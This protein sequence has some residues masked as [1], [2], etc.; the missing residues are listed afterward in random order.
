VRILEDKKVNVRLQIEGKHDRKK[1]LHLNFKAEV[2]FDV[3]EN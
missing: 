3:P 1:L 2:L